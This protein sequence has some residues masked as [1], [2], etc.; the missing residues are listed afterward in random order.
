M[1]IGLLI[2]HNF[3]MSKGVLDVW[4]DVRQLECDEWCNVMS[5]AQA[6]FAQARA[7]ASANLTNRD[8]DLLARVSRETHY[9]LWKEKEA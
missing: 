6:K 2:L 9:L 5:K 7:K 8:Q 1:I 4:S 3:M